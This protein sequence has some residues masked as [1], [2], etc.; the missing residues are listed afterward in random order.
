MKKEMYMVLV[1]SSKNEQSCFINGMLLNN[2]SCKLDMVIE[3]LQRY[4]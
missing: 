4:G 1:Q 3:T 2:G